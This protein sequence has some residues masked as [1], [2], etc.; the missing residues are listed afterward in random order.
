MAAFEDFEV[1]QCIIFLSNSFRFKTIF[2]EKWFGYYTLS[3]IKL[4]QTDEW[5]LGRSSNYPHNCKPDINSLEDQE[6]DPGNMRHVEEYIDYHTPSR[7]D[8]LG[9]FN[10]TV[11]NQF[12]KSTRPNEFECTFD[13][14]LCNGWKI[15]PKGI[16]KDPITNITEILSDWVVLKG[17]SMSLLTGPNRDHTTR[18]ATGGYIIAQGFSAIFLSEFRFYSPA[19]DLTWSEDYCLRIGTFNLV[20]FTFK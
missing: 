17:P 7:H 11:K 9:Y 5:F 3:S 20:M 10:K 14:G 8:Y 2:R 15:E 16:R 4:R 18:N 19:V 12:I 13:K 1:Y 6:S